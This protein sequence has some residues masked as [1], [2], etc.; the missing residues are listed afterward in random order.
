MGD[1]ATGEEGGGAES[2]E[3]LM[4]QALDAY[5]AEHGSFGAVDQETDAYVICVCSYVYVRVA[6]ECTLVCMLNVCPLALLLPDRSY[7]KAG[8]KPRP[9]PTMHRQPKV[10]K[11]RAQRM[12][13]SKWH[14]S[15]CQVFWIESRA[16]RKRR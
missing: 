4:E 8:E 11:Q 3:A 16:K 6:C 13:A 5:A 15:R 12:R 1:V 14:R 7:L 9:Q 2:F 10:S